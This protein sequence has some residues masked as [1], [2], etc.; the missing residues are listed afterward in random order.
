[1][2]GILWSFSCTLIAVLLLTVGSTYKLF[3]VMVIFLSVMRMSKFFWN[4]CVNQ[5]ITFNGNRMQGKYICSPYKL[6]QLANHSCE[7]LYKKLKN[8]H[9]IN[10]ASLWYTHVIKTNRCTIFVFISI[11]S[12]STCFEQIIVHHQE[13]RYVDCA[14]GKY[15]LAYCTGVHLSAVVSVI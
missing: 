11:K 14:F 9:S 7:F 5:L 13:V 6:Q 2:Y 1:M 15:T 4:C 10:C 12:S 3:K 8:L